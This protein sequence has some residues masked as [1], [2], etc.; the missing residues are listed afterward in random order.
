MLWVSVFQFISFFLLP[1]F[2]PPS[3]LLSLSFSFFLSFCFIVWVC[4]TLF[5][6][7]CVDGHV[8]C[9]QFLPVETKVVLVVPAFIRA[10]SFFWGKYL[11]VKSM[12]YMVCETLDLKKTKLPCY[13]TGF[14]SFTSVPAVCESSSC[15]ILYPTLGMVTL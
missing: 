6:H 15:S 3:Y 1:S 9:F 12:D 13:F 8:C 2:L 10:L 14:V 11:E 5:I 4:H 7:L